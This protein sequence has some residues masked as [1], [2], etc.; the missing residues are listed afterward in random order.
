MPKKSLL[1]TDGM[2]Y[3]KGGLMEA[4]VRTAQDISGINIQLYDKNLF[5][6]IIAP[7][8]I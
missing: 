1:G 6:T 3:L 4:Q 5:F 7:I 2:V 8:L